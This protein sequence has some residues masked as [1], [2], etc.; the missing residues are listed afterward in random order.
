MQ[1]EMIV[2]LYWKRDESAISETERKYGRYLS[3]IAY[4]ILSDWEDSKETVN[5]TYL[6][7][8]NS[9]PTHKPGALSTYLAQH[10]PIQDQVNIFGKTLDQPI[11][12][13]ETGASFE[14]EGRLPG[15]VMEEVVQ[16]QADPE[17]LFDD[18]FMQPCLLRGITKQNT[19][20][21]LRCFGDV[22]HISPPGRFF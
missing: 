8:W 1:D 3:K 22:I 2:A 20:V 16:C 6:K 12:F 13:G 14:C 4:N 15:T 9:M 7:A 17:V 5:D 11:A 10:A 19:A 21:L 18:S